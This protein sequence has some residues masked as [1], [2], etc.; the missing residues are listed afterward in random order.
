MLGKWQ[1]GH[2]AFEQQGN[3]DFDAGFRGFNNP[4]ED[5]FNGDVMELIFIYL[6]VAFCSFFIP[7]LFAGGGGKM[8]YV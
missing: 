5:L 1:V 7:F 6:S 8:E 2:E 3:P 4:F